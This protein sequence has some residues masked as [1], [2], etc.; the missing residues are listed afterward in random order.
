MRED[1]TSIPISDVFEPRDGCPICRM[2]NLLEERV[3]DYITGPAM[4]E[5]DVR[6]ETNKQGFCFTH[7]RMMLSGRSRLSVAQ[8]V[9]ANIDTLIEQVRLNAANW[10]YKSIR[11]IPAQRISWPCIAAPSA[12]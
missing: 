12:K 1:I 9:A 11:W 5:P 10:P 4:M 8:S 6:I 7:Y 3:A 2:R